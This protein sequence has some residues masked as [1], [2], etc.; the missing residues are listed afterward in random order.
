MSTPGTPGNFDQLWREAIESYIAAMSDDDFA[1]LIARVRPAGFSQQDPA[2][3][4]NSVLA[5]IAAK[6]RRRPSVDANG[7]PRKKGT[8]TP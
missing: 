6:Q 5:S 4:Q 2:Q 1:A 7:H 8:V 3:R